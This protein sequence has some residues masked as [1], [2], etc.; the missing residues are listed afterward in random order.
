MALAEAFLNA[1]L[2]ADIVDHRTYALVGDGCLQEGIAQEVIQLAGHLRLGKLTFLWDDNRMTDDGAI[3]IATTD[4]M[5]ARF[6]ACNWHVQDGGRPRHRCGVRG[7]RG[8]R[9]PTRARR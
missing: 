7:T 9:R 6:A 8:G 2:G 1:C 4:D 5:Q 3:E